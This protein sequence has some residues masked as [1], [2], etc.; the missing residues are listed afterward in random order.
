M[1]SIPV[2]NVGQGDDVDVASKSNPPALTGQQ[3][4]PME[5][6][7]NE[8]SEPSVEN[9]SQNSNKPDQEGASA[10]QVTPNKPSA[11]EPPPLPPPPPPPSAAESQS[12]LSQNTGP[13]ASD[14]NTTP[15]I[16]DLLFS[17]Q[18]AATLESMKETLR[19]VVLHDDDDFS[20][21][22][23]EVLRL[24]ASSLKS[25]DIISVMKIKAF[26][27]IWKQHAADSSKL[28]HMESTESIAPDATQL[29]E[30]LPSL[31]SR[32]ALSAQQCLDDSASPDNILAVFKARFP[33]I[34]HDLITK[35]GGFTVCK[36]AKGILSIESNSLSS[37]SSSSYSFILF[38]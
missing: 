13:I 5:T 26:L 9:P 33:E 3:D 2:T 37:S 21:S 4:D 15:V 6:N 18:Q 35:L 27:D 36:E 31:L 11:D 20:L 1:E 19:N 24:D 28:F 12:T 17:A 30:F 38:L 10:L 8:K 16:S 22:A 29:L 32:A 34:A 7:D 23:K 25:D 14:Q